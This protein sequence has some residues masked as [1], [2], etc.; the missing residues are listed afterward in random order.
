[1]KE[2]LEQAKQ[3]YMDLWAYHLQSALYLR[4]ERESDAA[5][6]KVIQDGREL[7]DRYGGDD[8]LKV[9]TGRLQ[10]DIAKTVRSGGSTG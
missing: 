10:D 2:Q 4:Q 6:K 7:I 8:R 3:F 5:W 9:F 1:M